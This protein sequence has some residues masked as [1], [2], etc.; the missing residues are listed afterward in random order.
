MVK[1]NKDEA[2]TSAKKLTNQFII[3]GIALIFLSAILAV[4]FAQRLTSPLITLVKATKNIAAGNLSQNISIQSSDEIGA[5]ASSFNNMLITRQQHEARIQEQSLQSQQMLKELAEQR[6]ALDQHAIVAITDIKGSITFVNKKF[7]EISGYE[8][9]ELLGK[10]H[11]ILN[12][13]THTK[14]LFTQMY[15]T[16]SSGKVWHGELCNRNKSGELYWVDT[17]IVPSMGANEKPQSY[18]AIRTEITKRKDTEK[19]LIQSEALNRGIFNAV[20][21]AIITINNQ[22]AIEAFN[23]AACRIFGY[24]KEEVAGKNICILMPESYRGA[25]Q[26]G[27]EKYLA[28]G[29]PKIL[30]KTVEVEGLRKGGGVFCL[31][32]TI[33]EITNGEQPKF[34]ASARDITQR[35]KI[36]ADLINAKNSA[37]IA[38]QAKSDFLAC[39]SHEIRTP[40]NGVLGMLGLLMKTK[41]SKDQQRKADVARSSAESLLS[42]INDILDFS[43]IDAGKLDLE[44]LDLN[45]RKTFG[46]FSET[47]ALRT[48]EK[49]LEFILDIVEIEHSMVKGDPSRLW[50]IL[51]NLVGNAI[52]FTATG[53]IVIK[54]SLTVAT[55][56]NLTL[57]CS[58]SDTGIGIPIEK[59]A[60]LFDTF[61]QV[62]ASTTRTY[63][64]TG[65]GLSIVKKLCTLMG[66][67]INVTSNPDKGSC[68]EFSITLLPSEHFK[69][70]L[71]RTKIDNLSLLVVANNRTNVNTLCKQLQHWGAQTH[72]TT[73]EADAITVLEK[74]IKADKINL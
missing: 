66:G 23:P 61:T 25:H 44:I 55:N 58:I 9:K 40:M 65:L 59:Q 38:A 41:L 20:A 7:M 6:F 69:K 67:G 49:G 24:K 18:I 51:T 16:I 21:D 3:I 32:L 10:N 64:G 17:T 37:E 33:S 14:D 1:I 19:A 60:A 35:K 8:E 68:F 42:L 28:T 72:G 56:D 13:G 62:D 12:S 36:E 54:A 31:E 71:P 39:M 26:R 22:G 4:L 74:N 27:L 57:H 45:L 43:K 29:I 5:L 50:Q 53:E 15:R 47:M 73:N 70:V 63:G 2:F 30:G 48:Q 52:K 34:T 46:D 11:R